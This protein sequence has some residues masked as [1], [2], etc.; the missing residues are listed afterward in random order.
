MT[1]IKRTNSENQDF[2][3]LVRNLDAYLAEID[4]EDHVFYDQFNKIGLIKYAVVVYEDKN[5]IGCGA[6]KEFDPKTMEVKRMYVSPQSRGIGIATRILSELENWAKELW[7]I[8]CVLETGRN[9]PHAIALYKKNGYTS[10]P[11]YGQYVGIAN[12]VCFEKLLITRES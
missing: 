2:V 4:G 5:P 3:L 1:R 9:Q 6:I 7:C 11:N 12:S 10:I 8:R